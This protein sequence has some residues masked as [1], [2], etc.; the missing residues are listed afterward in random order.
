[1]VDVKLPDIKANMTVEQASEFQLEHGTSAGRRFNVVDV[2]QLLVNF[3]DGKLSADPQQKVYD[4]NPV[5]EFMKLVKL[6]EVPTSIKV[7][8]LVNRMDLIAAIRGQK[9]VIAF[10]ER[11]VRSTTKAFMSKNSSV[12]D[13]ISKAMKHCMTR[14][15]G[16][17]V[18]HSADP[19]F[20]PKILMTT[21]DMKR[22]FAPVAMAASS[23]ALMA[24]TSD[25]WKKDH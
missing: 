22:E 9:V 25:N 23:V 11:T 19:Y 10:L 21:P 12:Q 8:P 7:G 4:H 15:P 18:V 16:H 2:Y 1:M 17:T 14:A 3:I 20:D 13:M 24:M 6:T 5:S